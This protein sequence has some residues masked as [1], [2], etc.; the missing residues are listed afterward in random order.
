MPLLKNCLTQS[1]SVTGLPD[2]VAGTIV[3]SGV[4]LLAQNSTE[5]EPVTLPGTDAAISVPTLGDDA[6][7]VEVKVP[8]SVI[9]PE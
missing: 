6:P 7:S 1:A 8:V 4:L 9:V 3:A 2:I 5:V